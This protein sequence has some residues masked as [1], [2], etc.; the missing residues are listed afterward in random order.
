MI[1]PSTS[2]AA[3]VTAYMDEHPEEADAIKAE[4]AKGKARVSIADWEPAPVADATAPDGEPVE[5]P[6]NAEAVSSAP[7]GQWE[8][9]EVDGEPVTVDGE[10]VRVVYPKPRTDLAGAPVV[11]A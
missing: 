3:D 8:R 11:P 7:A 1:D 9:L 6:E 4:E 5:L 2:T 10:E